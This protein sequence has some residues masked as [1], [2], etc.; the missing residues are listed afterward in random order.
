MIT[1]ETKAIKV[2]KSQVAKEWEM[3]DEGIL[4]WCLNLRVTRDMKRGLLKIDQ[5]Q[6]AKEILRRFNMHL[7][8]CIWIWTQF[9]T[10]AKT[11]KRIFLMH[12]QREVYC[13]YA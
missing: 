3:T 4:F 7:Y 2:F 11:T 10:R 1:D 13:I 12:Q 8:Y 6:Y 5:E 9:R